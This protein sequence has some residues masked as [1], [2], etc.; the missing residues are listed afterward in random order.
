MNP[1]LYSTP[2]VSRARRVAALDLGTT[3]V[4]CAVAEVG[5]EGV[6]VQGTGE[7]PSRGMRK[8]SVIDIERA[9]EAVAEAVDAAERMAGVEVSQV[10]V[11]LA[12]GHIAS[13]P[14]RGLVAVGA[15][16]DRRTREV[17]SQ[18]V[19][20][21]VEAARAV[22][23]PSDREIVHLLPRHFTVDGQDGVRDALGMTGMRLE[24]EA[25]IV[26]GATT[27]IQNVV[28]VVHEAGL[29]CEDLVLQVLAS[30]EA[31]LNE[32]E[33]ER[34]VVVADVGG[35]T[36]DVAVFSGGS[37]IHT[38]VI[39]V[40]GSHVTGDLAVGL[41]S[42]LETAEIIKRQYGHCLQLTL[43][44]DA[45]VTM[46]PMGYEEAVQVPQR[47]LA[48]VIG[49]RAREMA[50]L[51]V[52]EVERTATPAALAGGIVLTGGG[53]LLRGFCEVAQQVTDM[54]VRV[55]SPTGTAGMDESLRGPHHATVVGLL[56]WGARARARN[57]TRGNGHGGVG[58]D[59]FSE[60]F[61]RWLREL[62]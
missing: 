22:G 24:V 10:I 48:E 36:T 23:I 42:D 47:Y 40:G 17:R 16:G 52:A 49:P 13:Q 21:A 38:A 25:L 3:K 14:S 7:A 62:F 45:T 61:G 31:V 53:A 30:A 5:P 55:A 51:V 43:P 18:D 15:V 26:T 58:D 12:G 35:G 57:G 44:A 59:G 41:R 8:G 33:L 50:A 11:G 60:R 56:R 4:C 1:R 2:D 28:K 19:T 9:A 46:T 6:V 54:P 34:G 29:D 20:R 39:P 32:G 27:A 37:I